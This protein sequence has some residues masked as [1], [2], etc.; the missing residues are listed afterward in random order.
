MKRQRNK[1]EFSKKWLIACATFSIVVTAV[2]FMLSVFDKN[3]VESLSIS[4]IE[5]CWGANGVSFIGYIVQN[6]VRAY[7]SSKFGIPMENLPPMNQTKI[8]TGNKTSKS[9][10]SKTRPTVDEI[11]QEVEDSQQL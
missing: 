3:P 7:T 4:I 1:L 2:S 10:Q 8:T 9:Q 5:C 6:S 11:I